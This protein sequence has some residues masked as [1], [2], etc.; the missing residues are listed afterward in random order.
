MKLFRLFFFLLIIGCSSNNQSLS[1]TSSLDYDIL[2]RFIK[3]SLPSTLDLDIN[4]SDVFDQ[5]KDINLI[6][7]VKKIPL[8][9][10]KQL[11]FPINLLK[12][13]ILKI[14]DKNVP[15]A[16]NHP[17]IIGRFRVLKTDILKINIDD[18]SFENYKTF[19]KN[20]KDIIN[21]YNSFV[22]TMNLEVSQKDDKIILN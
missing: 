21:S 4:H 11:N 19:K 22:N 9:E 16:L 3:D 5:W 20:L 10:S 2:D 17:Q 6:N 1:N 18:L 15:H 13:D 8:I 7:T 12:T 14:N